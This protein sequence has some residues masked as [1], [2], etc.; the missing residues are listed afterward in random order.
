MTNGRLMT[1]VC[2]LLMYSSAPASA[3][4]PSYALD[5]LLPVG[6]CTS[7]DLSPDESLLYVRGDVRGF[8]AGLLVFDTSTCKLIDTCGVSSTPWK[9]VV[10]ADGQTV[11]CTRYYCGCVSEVEVDPFTC[12]ISQSVSVGSWPVDLLFDDAK[13]YLYV[14]EN[15]PGGDSPVSGSIEV[16][17]TWTDQL[18]AAIPLNGQ[19]GMMGRASMDRYLYTVTVNPG[20]GTETL[21]KIDTLDW[22]EAGTLPL[23]GLGGDVGISVSPDFSTVYVP[24]PAANMILVIDAA[25][26]TQIDSFPI[27][28]PRGFFVAPSGDHALVLH[29]ALPYISVVDLGSQ[30][31]IQTI[32][33]GGSSSDWKRRPIWNKGG[34]KAYVP[35]GGLTGG[36]AILNSVC[37]G[38]LD[39]D[40]D[41]G[42]K[43]LLILL[44]NWGVCR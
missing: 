37:S 31:I 36:V 18:V 15:H 17:D 8:E 5:C 13:R 33:V 44:G 21:Y 32:D 23:S 34:T 27:E 30:T 20:T 41:I 28:A 43:D 2:A 40:G 38:D 4:A 19:G 3:G 39:G 24:S 29:D 6:N 42:V 35:L 10:S 25:S 14:G 9:F 22:T 26:L 1:T 7:V 11:W 12:S 16:I